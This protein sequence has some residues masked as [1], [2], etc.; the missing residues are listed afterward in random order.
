MLSPPTK[1]IRY[2]IDWIKSRCISS[3]LWP[4][5]FEF[6][7]CCYSGVRRLFEGVAF[8]GAPGLALMHIHHLYLFIDRA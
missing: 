7:T 4:N 5:D 1:E 6:A 2:P 3:V 8:Y